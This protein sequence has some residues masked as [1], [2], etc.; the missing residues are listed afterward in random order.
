MTGGTYC[1]G[2]TS[3]P[4][5]S[6]ELVDIPDAAQVT[7]DP[8]V[9]PSRV[10][11]VFDLDKTVI[12]TS[13]SMAY[14][15]PLAD[16]GL[17]TTGEMLRLLLMLGNYTPVHVLILLLIRRLICLINSVQPKN[18]LIFRLFTLQAC[19][20]LPALPMMCVKAICAPCLTLF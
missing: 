13:A 6:T 19:P 10:L 5:E 7:T 16:R 9:D 15:K 14:R 12:D 18:S 3:V 20:V 8:G 17:I 1:R 2:V 4:E 11:A